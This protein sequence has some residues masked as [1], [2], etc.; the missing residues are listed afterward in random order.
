MAYYIT[1]T[2]VLLKCHQ[3]IFQWEDGIKLFTDSLP[4][5]QKM[6][7][8]KG[9]RC[10]PKMVHMPSDRVFGHIK[11]KTQQ[12]GLIDGRNFDKMCKNLKKKSKLQFAG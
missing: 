3:G 7:L 4:D 5:S 8:L 12:F 2:Q 10:H 6:S 9:E 1:K 11:T